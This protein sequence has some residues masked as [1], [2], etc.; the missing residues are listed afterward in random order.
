MDARAYTLGRVD[1]E[2]E[3]E[4]EKERESRVDWTTLPPNCFRDYSHPPDCF[5]A[6]TP[7][8]HKGSPGGDVGARYARTRASSSAQ[9]GRRPT[10][11]RRFSLGTKTGTR[12]RFPVSELM[13]TVPA[14]YGARPFWLN[15]AAGRGLSSFPDILAAVPR[16]NFYSCLAGMVTGVET[17]PSSL[18]GSSLIPRHS[19]QRLSAEA[20]TTRERQTLSS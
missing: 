7:W 12:W 9:S 4:R 3:R 5:Q 11:P 18:T 8:G 16:A 1:I 15:V 19:H 13:R 6:A 10:P 14:R 2:Q 20:P 17:K